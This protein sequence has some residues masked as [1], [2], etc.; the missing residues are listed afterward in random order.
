VRVEIK[1]DQQRVM[2]LGEPA[3]HIR[4]LVEADLGQIVQYQLIQELPS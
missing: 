3:R 2:R 4:T 1:L